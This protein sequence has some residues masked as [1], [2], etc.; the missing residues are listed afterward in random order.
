MTTAGTAPASVSF[1]EADRWR[2]A[3]FTEKILDLTDD[4]YLS[5]YAATMLRGMLAA[6]RAGEVHT[7]ED[8]LL[9]GRAVLLTELRLDVDADIRAESWKEQ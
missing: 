8:M 1:T 4:P 9:R 6:V 5:G 3:M 7:F 2:A